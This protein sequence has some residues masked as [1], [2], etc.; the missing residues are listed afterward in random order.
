MNSLFEDDEDDDFDAEDDDDDLPARYEDEPKP[1]S[2]IHRRQ[3][4]PQPMSALIAKRRVRTRVMSQAMSDR[5]PR[6]VTMLLTFEDGA[7]CL[8]VRK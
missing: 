3:P 7:Q 4:A 8:M 6:L 2:V 1:I 5:Y